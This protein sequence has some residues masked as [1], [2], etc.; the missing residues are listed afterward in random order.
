LSSSI[1]FE[2]TTLSY[3]KNL[4]I[5]TISSNQEVLTIASFLKRGVREG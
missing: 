3:Q 2:K 5:V 1:K 4:E